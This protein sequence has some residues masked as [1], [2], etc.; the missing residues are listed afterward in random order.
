MWARFSPGELQRRYALTRGLMERLDLEALVIFGNSGVNRHN[1]VNAFWLSEWLDQHHCYLVVPRDE[2][3]A[4]ALYVGLTNHVPNAREVSAVPVIEW[5]GYEAGETVARRLGELGIDRGRVGLVGVG[6]VWTMGMPWQHYLGLREVLPSVELA[7]VTAEYAKLRVVKS[8]EEIER[9]REAA[10]LTDLAIEALQRESRPG[11]SEEE[12]VAVAEDAYRRRGGMVRITFLRSMPMDAPNGCLPSQ[13]PGD[14]RIERG[15]V[16]ITE[17]S[18]SLWGYSGQIHR[19]VFVG[20]EPTAE[21]QRMF[22]VAKEAYDRIAA[23]MRAGSTEGDAI[24]NAAVIGAAGYAIY[25]DL[26]HGYG[27]DIHPPFVDRSCVEYWQ[28]GREPPPGR[29]IEAGTAIVIQ[30]NPVTPDERMGLQLGALTIVRDD[31]AE[32]LHTIPFEPLLASV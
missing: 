14:R 4:S 22:D 25:D 9:L 10:A 1:N 28:D 8:E 31:G 19:P 20:A 11:V 30:P 16:I 6:H 2:D 21:W 13:N 15:D 12:L 23:G 27:T 3:A 7:E 29:M 26:I 17:F 18:A 5:G 24:R 32:C